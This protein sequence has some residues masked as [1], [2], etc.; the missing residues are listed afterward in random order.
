MLRFGVNNASPL[1]WIQNFFRERRDGLL[2]W[3]MHPG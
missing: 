2:Q 1:S 3:L